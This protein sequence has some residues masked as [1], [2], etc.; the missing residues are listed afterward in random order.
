MDLLQ[1][2][3]PN[4]VD[5]AKG[6]SIAFVGAGGKTTAMFRLARQFIKAGKQVVFVSTSTHLGQWQLGLADMVLHLDIQHRLP[7]QEI[8]K[9]RGVVLL[10]G[11]QINE[12]RVSGL[13]ETTLEEIYQ[14]TSQLGA[15]LLIEA[16]GSRGLPLKAPAVHEPAVPG[17]VDVVV[18]VSGL[19]A[20]G[21]PLHEKVVHRP[22]IFSMLT[23]LPLG[24]S[25]RSDEFVAFLCNIY[26]GLKNIPAGAIKVALLNQADT[27][28]LRDMGERIALDIR[29]AYDY[30]LVSS[31][32]SENEE[33]RAKFAP[34]AGIIL[35]AGGARRFGSPKQLIRYDGEPLFIRAIR[36]GL[37]AG[38]SPL[39]LVVGAY[40]DEILSV[41]M[42]WVSNSN[43][44]LEVIHNPNWESGQSTSIKAGL[45]NI[46]ERISGAVFFP[47]DQPFISVDLIHALLCR[48]SETQAWVVH[49]LVQGKRTSPVLFSSSMFSE[50][51]GLTG[52]IGGRALLRE[53]K[54]GRNPIP[55]AVVN[56][57]DARLA[58]DIDSSEDYE[59]FINSQRK[60]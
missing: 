54:S 41:L 15:P 53:P 52:D 7:Y 50:L 12:S 24:E 27:E 33:V 9:A 16:D 25:I 51:R 44:P 20:L 8:R 46:N 17:F 36:V 48:Q 60:P 3:I 34:V 43:A 31:L 45:E 6:C 37:D 32:V 42:N 22:E 55:V 26:R 47:I 2:L 58:W 28:I 13:S 4:P 14:E 29:S 38:L 1:A 18:V 11:P 5:L 21:K 49:P 57:D 10:I 59:R 35:A 19:S 30:C 39:R 40:Q 56:W 23:G